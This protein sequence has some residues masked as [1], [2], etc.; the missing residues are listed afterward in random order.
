M[1]RAPH[2]IWNGNIAGLKINRG[3]VENFKN[4]KSPASETLRLQSQW[5]LAT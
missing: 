5:L 2:M 4:E 3:G 1:A